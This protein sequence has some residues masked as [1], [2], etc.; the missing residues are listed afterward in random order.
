MVGSW[1]TDLFGTTMRYWLSQWGPRGGAYRLSTVLQAGISQVRFFLLTYSPF[2][3]GPGIG[4][5]RR[6]FLL[7]FSTPC[8][9]NVNITGTQKR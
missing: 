4:S 9:S 6:N 3:Y 8:I 2:H 7:N 1:M 5:W